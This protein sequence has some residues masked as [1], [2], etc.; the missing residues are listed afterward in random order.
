MNQ[1]K[2]AQKRHKG[3]SDVATKSERKKMLLNN[4][5]KSESVSKA[6]I[7]EDYVPAQVSTGKII[8]VFYYAKTA[9]GKLKR[10]VI[11]CNRGRNK[12]ECL[13][14]ARMVA[15]E[16]NLKLEYG[17]SPDSQID[18][19]VAAHR[20]CESFKGA[21]EK[22]LA[23]KSKELRPD[24]MRS[25]NS[26]C[27]YLSSY[28]TEKKL[29]DSAVCDYTERQAKSLMEKIGEEVGKKTFNNYLRFYS[30]F[31]YWCIEKEFC[32][33]N[34]FDN[35][36]VKKLDE[37]NRDVIPHD[38]RFQIQHYIKEQ[39]MYPYYIIMLLCFRCLIRPKEILMLKFK[40]IDWE[41]GV[42]N[43][44]PDVAKNH[45]ARVV[46]LPKEIMD[47]FRTLKSKPENWYIFS[48]HYIPGLV[49]KNTR[50]ID[51]TWVEIRTACNLPMSYKFY[52]LK[53]SGITEML[54][55]D[56]PTK[57]VKE[58]ADHHS[59]AMTEKYT[60]KSKAHEILKQTEGKVNF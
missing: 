51:K 27:N 54:E 26:F 12:A 4:S 55:A 8:R 1:L 49:L 23:T 41:A 35:I 37:K 39:G 13:K 24:S 30:T 32:T 16:L 56:V 48:T 33:D 9:D 10:Y 18:I 15:A 40:M 43:I 14:R 45:K 59:L 53:D 52:S 11:K 47:Y 58:L 22:F 44:P 6:I 36:K 2:T 42:L 60:H 57:L 28:L 17:W 38:V 21:I 5:K 7:F 25:Y 31:F 3:L 50:D 19:S 29:I 34:P 20:D 46:A